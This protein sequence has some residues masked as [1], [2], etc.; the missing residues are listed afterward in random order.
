VGISSGYDAVPA[1]AAGASCQ[2]EIGKPDSAFSQK[3]DIRGLDLLVSITS[4]VIP[5]NIVGNE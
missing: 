2:K 3:I 5:A 1:W 4:K